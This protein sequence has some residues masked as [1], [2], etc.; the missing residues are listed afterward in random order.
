MAARGDRRKRE[1]RLAKEEEKTG[2]G[3][4]RASGRRAARRSFSGKLRYVHIG[5]FGFQI[6]FISFRFHFYYSSFVIAGLE[7]LLLRI[8]LC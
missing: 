7:R 4:E 3:E 1:E 8:R 2:L 6:S 5:C